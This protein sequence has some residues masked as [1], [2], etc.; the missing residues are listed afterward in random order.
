MLSIEMKELIEAIVYNDNNIKNIS[1]HSRI[2][3]YKS[4][5]EVVWDFSGSKWSSMKSKIN[6]YSKT[7]QKIIKRTQ[8]ALFG[9]TLRDL[10]EWAVNNTYKEVVKREKDDFNIYTMFVAAYK[11]EMDKRCRL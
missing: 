10:Q 4:G 6:S 5:G 2:R 8:G 7:T 3:S 11:F 9:D 1:V